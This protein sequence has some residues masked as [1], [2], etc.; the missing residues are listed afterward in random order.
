MVLLQDSS[1]LEVES[2]KS[3]LDLTWKTGLTKDQN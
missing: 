3:L 2:E 1:T